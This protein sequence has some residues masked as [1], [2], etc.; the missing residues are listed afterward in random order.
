M[1]Y[2]AEINGDDELTPEEEVKFILQEYEKGNLATL[3]DLDQESET[4]VRQELKPYLMKKFKRDTLY[5]GFSTLVVYKKPIGVEARTTE[6]NVT[7]DTPKGVEDEVKSSLPADLPVHVTFTPNKGGKSDDVVV[8][9]QYDGGQKNLGLFIRSFI[10]D[11][12]EQHGGAGH[13]EE[14]S[15]VPA[16]RE[17]PFPET[18]SESTIRPFIKDSFIDSE[19]CSVNRM[20]QGSLA[21]KTREAGRHDGSG[22]VQRPW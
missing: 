21:Y 3:R 4:R 14:I 20:I 2:V 7:A 8:A 16:R 1:I 10:V 12:L 6:D 17:G 18:F 5:S 22:R 9:V 11:N 13:R 15:P 19:K